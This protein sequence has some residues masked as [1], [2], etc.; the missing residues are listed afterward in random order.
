MRRSENGEPL[1]D[2]PELA[3][4]TGLTTRKVELLLWQFDF[5][6][7]RYET[8]TTPGGYCTSRGYW[9]HRVADILR[10]WQAALTADEDAR[11][12]YTTELPHW[13]SVTELASVLDVSRGE[14]TR[15]AASCGVE[16]RIRHGC[17]FYRVHPSDWTRLAEAD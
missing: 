4:L 5:K 11:D 1:V 7:V 2:V 6:P 9:R 12:H 8:A 3:R 14:A 16:F 13:L 15:L 17:R 10:D